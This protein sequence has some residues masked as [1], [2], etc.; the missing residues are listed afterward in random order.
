[1]R[2]YVASP[3]EDWRYAQ[4]AMAALREA[5]HVITCDWTVEAVKYPPGD[6]EPSPEVRKGAAIADLAGVANA[7][8]VLALTSP[9]KE[10]G[11]GMWTEVGYAIGR[12]VPFGTVG[13][14]RNRSVFCELAAF[15][16]KTVPMAVELLKMGIMRL[17]PLLDYTTLSGTSMRRP[18]TLRTLDLVRAERSRQVRLLEDRKIPF[19]CADT[20]ASREQKLSVLVEEVG[21]VARVVCEAS[22]THDGDLLGQGEHARKLREELVQV[23]A[24][25]TAWAETFPCP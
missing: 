5:G 11:C 2:V 3:F 13:E 17:L 4:E 18:A 20:K 14:M 23:A 7:D 6:P 8:F 12:G 25:A 21:E 1:M 24:V 9:S 15:Q 16:V 22:Q 19:D 10:K